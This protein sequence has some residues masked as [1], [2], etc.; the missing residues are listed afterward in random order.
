MC[1]AG[2]FLDIPMVDG[3]GSVMEERYFDIA[4]NMDTKPALHPRCL[5]EEVCMSEDELDGR[6]TR[7]SLRLR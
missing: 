6:S 4:V 2:V 5:A 7:D 1:D 3:G